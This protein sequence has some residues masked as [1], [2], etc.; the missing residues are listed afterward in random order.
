MTT[1]SDDEMTEEELRATTKQACFER[2]QLYA[3]LASAR[4]TLVTNRGMLDN[5]VGRVEA[6]LI[7]YRGGQSK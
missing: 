6:V 7:A 4:A 5:L 2:D 1:V 3:M